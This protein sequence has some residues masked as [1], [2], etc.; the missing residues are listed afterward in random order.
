MVVD[1]I[2]ERQQGDTW[3]R[4]SSADLEPGDMTRLKKL[5]GSIL[6]EGKV[7][8]KKATDPDSNVRFDL[9]ID[10]ATK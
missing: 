10:W 6:G 9:G 4:T 8:A 7:A 2:F 5:D 1:V 3:V